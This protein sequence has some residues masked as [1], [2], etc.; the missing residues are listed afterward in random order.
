MSG[1]EAWAQNRFGENVEP[2]ADFDFLVGMNPIRDEPNLIVR[3]LLKT[4]IM[5]ERALP[6]GTMESVVPSLYS[7]AFGTREPTDFF[8]WASYIV[9]PRFDFQLTRGFP[10]W[11]GGR[12]QPYQVHKESMN[13]V[14][15][16]NHLALRLFR[17][18][19]A[20]PT[21]KAAV[22]M[23]GDFRSAPMWLTTRMTYPFPNRP[24]YPTLDLFIDALEVTASN[25]IEN[26]GTH[27]VS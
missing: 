21:F 9:S 14:I 15:Q 16:M 11:N 27:K 25:P 2:G 4:A 17:C 24:I 13:F 19:T 10:V 22:R 7:V 1:L 18:P 26:S 20:S 12:L 8:V 3:W 23:E 5:V 6:R